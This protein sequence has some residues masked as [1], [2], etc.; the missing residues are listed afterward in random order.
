MVP[1]PCSG[2]ATVL[3][4]AAETAGTGEVQRKISLCQALGEGL[5]QDISVVSDV[6]Q[7]GFPWAEA[8]LLEEQKLTPAA[9]T[10]R[11][12]PTRPELRFFRH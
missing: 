11:D 7:F 4:W 2:T 5:A 10:A 3:P 1:T 8:A 9:P 12:L 6:P